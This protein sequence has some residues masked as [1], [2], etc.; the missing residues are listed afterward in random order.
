MIMVLWWFTL[1][2]TVILCQIHFIHAA[3]VMR[4]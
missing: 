2:Y 4:I 1:V 3:M